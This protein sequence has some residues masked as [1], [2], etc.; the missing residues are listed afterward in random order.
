MRKLFV[1][2]NKSETIHS[3]MLWG[4]ALAAHLRVVLFCSDWIQSWNCKAIQVL[5]EWELLCHCQQI[6][7]TEDSQNNSPFQGTFHFPRNIWVL[8][9]LITVLCFILV[10]K[11]THRFKEIFWDWNTSGFLMLRKVYGSLAIIQYFW[12][13]DN[14]LH[15]LCVHHHE[16]RINYSHTDICTS[17]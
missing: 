6:H 7:L 16:L 3:Y 17:K 9:I 10:L 14:V 5:L 13:S 15:G 4:I 1:F 11:Y 8:Y 2:T 12:G